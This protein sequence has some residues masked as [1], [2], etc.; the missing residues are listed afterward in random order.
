M[1]IHSHSRNINDKKIQ[2]GGEPNRV[3]ADIHD[4]YRDL[5]KREIRIMHGYLYDLEIQQA[6]YNELYISAEKLLNDLL[7]FQRTTH[8]N[9]FIREMI[10]SCRRI[11][12]KIQNSYTNDNMNGNSNMNGNLNINGGAKKKKVTKKRSPAKSKKLTKKKL[13]KKRSTTKKTIKS[14]KTTKRGKS[15]K[16]TK[17]H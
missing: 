13:T 5:M 6:M 3:F 12:H 15:Q 17:K 7:D 8:N 10:S 2:K 4:R 11:V 16:T 1:S 9:E 14:K